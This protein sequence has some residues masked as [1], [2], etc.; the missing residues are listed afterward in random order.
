MSIARTFLEHRSPALPSAVTRLFDQ[1]HQTCGAIDLQKVIIVVPTARSGRRLRELLVVAAEQRGLEFWPPQ[2]VTVGR[3]PELLY[4][5]KLKLASTL[6]Q[7][8]AWADALK[9][10]AP[11]I[12]RKVIP[13]AP[14]Q[15]KNDDADLGEA[16]SEWRDS[17]WLD[18]GTLIC[19]Q[20]RTLAAESLTFSDVANHTSQMAA[21]PESQRWSALATIQRAY[22][23]QLD[24]VQLWDRQTARVVAVRHHE[25]QTDSDIILL[26]TVDVNRVIRD[27]LAQIPERVSAW[28]HAPQTWSDRFDEFGCLVPDAWHDALLDIPDTAIVHVNG[29]EEQALAVSQV[30]RKLE[31]RF[32]ID[33]IT[34]GMPDAKLVPFIQRELASQGLKSH[35]AGGRRVCQSEPFLLL[36]AV[37]NYFETSSAQSVAALVRHPR[38]ALRVA[39]MADHGNDWL[40]ELDRAY[41]DHLP[42]RL[43]VDSADSMTSETLQT[44]SHLLP[45]LCGPLADAAPEQ[46]LPKWANAIEELLLSSYAGVAF[47][48]EDIEQSGVADAALAIQDSLYEM[49]SLPLAVSPT[50]TAAEAIR[51]V[52]A[53]VASQSTAVSSEREVIELHGWLD[54]QLDDSP[55]L[56]L[57]SVHERFIPQSITSDLFLPNQLRVKLGIDD[58]QRRYARDAY[59]LTALVNS[60]EYTRLIVARRN[61]DGDP[62][63]PSR[64]LLAEENAIIAK[65]CLRFFSENTNRDPIFAE[66]SEPEPASERPSR[67]GPPHPSQLDFQ[68]VE[69]LSPTAFRTYIACKYRFFLSHVLR[70][71]SVVEDHSQMDARGFGNLMHDV[72]ESFGNFLP[73]RDCSETPLIQAYLH[74][75]L[76]RQAL[77]NFGKAPPPAVRI[78][79][80]SMR[81]RLNR[82]AEQQASRVADGWRTIYV[83]E[84]VEMIFPGT[85][86]KIVGKMDRIDVNPEG[87]WA[88]FD[89]KSGD[90]GKTP[91]QAH[92]KNRGKE[93]ID[94]QLP[95][96]FQLASQ[97]AARDDAPKFSGNMRL[98]FVLLPSDLKKVEFVLAPWSAFDLEQ[99]N[100]RTVKIIEQIQADDFW[101]PADPPPAFADWA[102]AICLDNVLDRGK[103][104]SEAH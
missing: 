50:V 2:I 97:L 4:E 15:K 9:R 39:G 77:A 44:F 37:A 5:P 85:T 22:L 34:I 54:L 67:F 43:F 27:M 46:A 29:P 40:I 102:A 28:I 7:N 36:Q 60:R 10:T 33:E 38:V 31:G 49:S 82:F 104:P 94:L 11:S 1:Y 63:L 25:V 65:R 23:D 53:D 83:E 74:K 66:L 87:D 69:H 19:S 84:K 73:M 32:A 99:A 3:L 61:V 55:A 47:D 41:E 93:W 70:L 62:E 96:Y 13:H 51:Y 58:N 80:E 59:A 95:L 90:S 72:L 75:E 42:T 71:N 30:L 14:D 17:E 56:L 68:T 35:W 101:P 92:R 16:S 26:G 64:L 98:G 91:D 18:Y 57:T 52:L 12:V 6:T 78:Q 24:Q 103:T 45:K 8:V 81:L 76:D 21:G 88:V 79:I 89:Y 20:Y 100:Q 86:M 48:S